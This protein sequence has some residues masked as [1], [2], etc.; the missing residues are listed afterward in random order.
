MGQPWIMILFRAHIEGSFAVETISTSV[1]E[2]IPGSST[3]LS[4]SALK[5]S[6]WEVELWR[7]Y[8]LGGVMCLSCM[9]L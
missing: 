2:V 8:Q 4:M 9:S 1:W 5:T 3:W 6:W 7:V